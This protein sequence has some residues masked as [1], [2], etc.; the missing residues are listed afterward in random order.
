VTLTNASNGLSF[1]S[2]SGDCAT[3]FPCTLGDIPPKTSR[4]V[5]SVFRASSSSAA[6]ASVTVSSPSNFNPT[7]DI[8]TVA[9]NGTSG[10]KGGASN[11]GG[12]SAGGPAPL[13]WMGLLSFLVFLRRRPVSVGALANR[14][15][16]RG[17]NPVR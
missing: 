16:F 12:C 6:S 10:T 11:S 5:T 17:G 14:R 1:V 2:N 15:P 3:A 9:V 4:V 13:P 7:N 8:A